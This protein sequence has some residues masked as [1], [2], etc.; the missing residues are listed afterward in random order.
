MSTG[1]QI[2]IAWYVV[3]D[4]LMAGLAWAV[5]YFIRRSLLNDPSADTEFQV[6]DKYFITATLLIPLGWLALFTIAGSYHSL[7][8]KSRLNEFSST[9]FCCIVGTTLLFFIFVMDD[10]QTSSAAGYYNRALPALFFTHF[11]LIFFGR[12]LIL[13]KVKTQLLGGDVFF[14]TLIVGRSSNAS[15]IYQKTQKHLQNGGYRYTGFIPTIDGDHLSGNPQLP[16]AGD[17][18]DLERVIDRNDIRLIV[19]ALDK[20]QSDLLEDLLGRLSEKDVRIKIQPDM[21]DILSGSVK[22]NNVMGPVLIDLNTGL[23]PLWQEHVKRLID[24]VASITGLIFLSPLMILAMIRVTLSSKGPVFYS[25]ERIGYK[26]RPFRMYKFRSM[27]VEAETGG[28]ALSSD[29]DPRITR[30]GKVMRKWRIDELPQLWNILKGDMS[31]VGPRPERRYFIDQIIRQHPYYKYLL[32]VKPGLTSWGMLQFG[33]A[34][35]VDQMIERSKFDLL[36]IENTSLALDF[37][38]MIHTVRIIFK[39]KGK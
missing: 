22:T 15:V 4:Y 9:L 38:I 8:P 21:M 7:Y 32:K 28:P 14:N 39:G 11:F 33:Y 36:Y 35:N 5:C 2:S 6:L 24:V 18:A 25:Q 20:T 30:W 1:K 16:V 13:R 17:F 3:S 37:K 19:L 10:V 34:E 31:L 26:G 23:M 29:N 27:I 12:W